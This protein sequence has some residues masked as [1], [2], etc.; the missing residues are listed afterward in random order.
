MDLAGA[1]TLRDEF[2]RLINTPT[3][4]QAHLPRFVSMC[5][6]LNA[7]HVIEL[8]TRTGVSTLAWL[9]G[10][11]QTGGRLTSVDIDPAP[12]IGSYGHWEFIQGD[13]CSPEVFG[14][15]AP[16]DIILID[17]SHLYDHTVREL[18]LYRHLVK[19]GGRL[20]LHDT[21]LERPEGAPARPRFPVRVAIEEFCAAE[22]YEW[23][24]YPDS[25]G[26]GVIQL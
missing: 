21:Q 11:E 26:L 4:I 20:V 12:Q 9:Y 17:T 16:A 18:H 24:E 22:G 10:L 6:N 19:P 1:V 25:W 23:H 14:R 8:G 3:D 5:I 2:Q 7:Q 13:D 15:L